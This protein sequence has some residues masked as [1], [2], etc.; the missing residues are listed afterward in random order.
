MRNLDDFE[1]KIR[2]CLLAGMWFVLGFVFAI[3]FNY[4]ISVLYSTENRGNLSDSNGRAGKTFLFVAV[5]SSHKTKHLRNAAR[6][7]WL[8]LAAETNHRIV[9]RFFVGSL[10]LPLPW[11]ESLE[12]ESREFNDM[13]LLRYVIDSYDELT[14][15]LLSSIEWIV[16]DFSFDYLLKLDDDSFARI[17]AIADE[18]ATWKR[19]RPDRDLYWGFFS[20]NAPVFKSGKWAEPVWY[21][22]DGYYLPYA[23]GG[24]YV[25][26]NRTVTLIRMFGFYFDKYFSEDVSVGVWVAPLK[27]DRRH[28]RR[29]DTE[30]RSRGCFNSYLVT[31]KQTAPM[32]YNKY[33]NL[34]RYGVLCEREVRSRLTY[35]YNWNVPPSACCVRNMTDAT[36]KRQTKHWQHTL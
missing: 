26:S 35:E 3:W 20:G 5:L 29:F 13:V 30:Y 1:P 15:K 36:L 28:D 6:Q 33:E 11:R 4:F 2:D 19:D 25:L 17:D 21:L 7:T 32:M 8:K 10:G 24:G 12:E 23:R 18:L 16:D 34:K 14:D 27:M 31:H 22:R 9:Y